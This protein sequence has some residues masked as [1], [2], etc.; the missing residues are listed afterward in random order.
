[1]IMYTKDN[2]NELDEDVKDCLDKEQELNVA[3]WD[4]DYYNN[5]YDRQV[6]RLLK[7]RKLLERDLQVEFFGQKNF[8]LVLVNNK[9]VVCLL[10]NEWR[11]VRKNKWYKHKRDL[12]H[13]IDNYILGDK[14]EANA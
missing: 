4:K 11:S 5:L 12:D 3:R 2:L 6:K 1:M 14:N 8:G 13:L 10:N 9:F 7:L